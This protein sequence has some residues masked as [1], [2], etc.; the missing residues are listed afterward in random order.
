MKRLWRSTIAA[1]LV[2]GA[3]LLTL[4]VAVYLQA[5]R[6]QR[7]AKRALSIVRNF[8]PGVTPRTEI[9]GLR[10]FGRSFVNDCGRDAA[11]GAYLQFAD[12]ASWESILFR[13][14]EWLRD[15]EAHWLL[16]R[17]TMFLISIRCDANLIQEV[18]ISEAQTFEGNPH[19]YSARTTLLPPG[20]AANY[21]M[22]EQHANQKAYAVWTSGSAVYDGDKLIATIPDYRKVVYVTRKVRRKN[23]GARSIFVSIALPDCAVART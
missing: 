10:R 21:E 19:P 23:A 9:A 17:G 20:V 14:P 2:L 18:R 8:Q 15:L 6:N 13:G 7:E 5:W 12:T 22:G 11:T 16:P 1:L 3:L 4:K